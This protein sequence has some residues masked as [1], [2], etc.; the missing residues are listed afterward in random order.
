MLYTKP[1]FLLFH[2]G[3]E[4]PFPSFDG[5]ATVEEYMGAADHVCA[6][7]REKL[8][9]RVHFLLKVA[10]LFDFTVGCVRVL[11]LLLTCCSAS[12]GC[13]WQCFTETGCLT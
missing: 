8:Q 11:T 5:P 7:L 12:L 4:T 3:S 2:T 13:S 9:V 10:C 1:S 6:T